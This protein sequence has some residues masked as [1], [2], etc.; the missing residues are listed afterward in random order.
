MGIDYTGC[1]AIFRSFEYVK[2][3]KRLLT[4]GRQ[5]IHIAPSTIND[6]LQKNN[7]SHLVDKYEWGFCENLFIDL[8]F[9]HV[10]SLDASDYEN[11][12]IIHNMNTPVPNHFQKYDYILDA[13]T[14]EH[15]FNTPQV[16][17][18]IINM[19]NIDGIFVSITPNNNL[20]GHGIYQFSP[21]FYLSAF[22][23]KYGM[24]VKA[25]YLAKVGSK[26]KD[27]INVNTYNI[28]ASGRNMSKFNSNE[29]VYVIAI[30]QKISNDRQ[31][32]IV[33]SPNQHSYENI[34]WAK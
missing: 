2:N 25:L 10:D 23:N 14:T 31:S 5:G 21:E 34:D 7:Y 11:A 27:W 17:E 22:S 8:G 24:E 26:Y 9:E 1:D 4:L 29:H 30:I 18:N 28:D 33:N 13:G 16:C 32:L 12:N 15:I 6:F 19:L 3:R 20:S